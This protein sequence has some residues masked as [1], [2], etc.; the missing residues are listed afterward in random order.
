[1][2]DLTKGNPIKL[3]FIFSLPIF[4]GNIFQLFYNLADTYIVGSVLGDNALAAVGATS[5]I[6]SL[7]IGFLIGLTNGFAVI[8][9]R[10]FG[11]KDY[12]ALK[13]TGA[14]ALVLTVATALILTILSVLFLKHILTWLN[15]PKDILPQAIS[16]IR[17]ILSA[18]TVAAVYNL[19]AAILRSVGD[20]FTPLIF[21]IISALIN[22]AL[23]YLFILC[24]KTSVEGAAAATVISQAISVLLCII[25]IIK[26][27]PLFRLKLKDLK[28]SS[29]SVK[30][31]YSC[32]LS[33]GFMMSF[34]FFGTLALQGAINTMGSDIII[35]HMA[36]RKL[37]E[38][39]MLPFSVAGTAMATYCSQN[40]G[41]GKIQRIKTGIKTVTLAVWI[42][43]IIVI[44][45]SYTLVPSFIEAITST[46]S[47]KVIKTG[48]LYLKADTLLYFVPA[49]IAVLRN[50]MQ[51][52]GDTKTP[53]FSSF[54]EL[55]GK[56]LIAS[57]TAPIFGYWAIIAAEPIVWIFMVIPLI[58]MMIK[59]PV[60]VKSGDSSGY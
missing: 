13:K 26:K 29:K 27:Y 52:I 34:V 31:L 11:A 5:P 39:F 42:W 10:Y 44:I 6:N 46:D 14:A 60:F 25:Y 18:M 55:L 1:M 22:V 59:N 32:G 56:V 58:V 8:T 16:Y 9:A 45:T 53:I 28:I 47:Y 41:A 21:L 7:I 51:G 19:L 57:F 2:N 3:I 38:V 12:K 37:T 35:A 54:I 17:I 33:M 43:C 40:L 50:S 30:L 36:A 48:S 20:T 24:L 23:D 4:A 49:L 15:T